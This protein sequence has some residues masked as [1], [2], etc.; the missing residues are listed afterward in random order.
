MRVN[1]A[2]GDVVID[3]SMTLGGAQSETEG[4]ALKLYC[5]RIVEEH[6]DD[7]VTATQAGVDKLEERICTTM[8]ELC[9]KAAVDRVQEE[10][11]KQKLIK[12]KYKSKL[13]TMEEKRMNKKIKKV[14]QLKKDMKRIVRIKKDKIRAQERLLKD[15]DKYTNQIKTLQQVLNEAEEVLQEEIE[16]QEQEN[17]EEAEESKKEL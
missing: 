9:G 8:L 3:G 7:W 11:T 16:A 14:T 5:D 4:R 1:Y 2:E 17:K 6:E 13:L 15:I 12:A 10:D